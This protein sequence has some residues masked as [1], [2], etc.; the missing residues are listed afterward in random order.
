M[1]ILYIN[2][3]AGSIYHGME[4]RPYYLAR[5]W[6][7]LGHKVTIIASNISHIRNKNILIPDSQNYLEEIIDGIKYIWCRTTPYN[8]NGIRRVINIFTFLYRLKKIMPKLIQQA[9][10]DLV[11]ASST[12][13][14]DT[15]IA[16][17][18]AKK[19]KAK[20]IY[21]IHDL[22]PLTPIELNGMSRLH[23]FIWLM[24]R[25][26]DFGYKNADKVVSL[27]PK[28]KNYMCEHGMDENKFVYIP[29]GVSISDW[30]TNIEA[31][32]EQ[33]LNQILQLK[34]QYA[35]LIGYAGGMGEANALDYVLSSAKRLPANAFILVGDGALKDSLLRRITS[36]NITNVFFMPAIN[37][38]QIPDFLKQM[39]ALYIGWNKLPIYRFGICPNKLFDYML[40]AKPIIH[41]VTAGNDLVRDAHCGVSVPAEDV[42]AITHA[43]ET[44]SKQSAEELNWLGN[45][46]YNY[47][48]KQ[49][50]YLL[51]ARKF[52][53]ECGM[54]MNANI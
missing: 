22:W 28:A 52:L 41:S 19:T 44:L 42:A 40:S 14:F 36:E 49:H 21:E 16:A 53:T 26:E 25:A 1:N 24:Q 17:K 30:Q 34:K 31:I 5:E 20:F 18:I 3:Y 35:F 29:N 13:P 4:Y 46:G 38:M 43:I 12:Y 2:H 37:K 54:E 8:G 47:V 33:H 15:K 48:I 39:D 32:P 23:P 27:L 45:N 6:V 10:P 9:K 11:I 7:K 50:D 51:L